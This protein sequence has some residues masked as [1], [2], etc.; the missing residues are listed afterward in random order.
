M[1]ARRAYHEPRTIEEARAELERCAGSQFDPQVVKTFLSVLEEGEQK[2]LEATFS[3][4][5]VPSD[6]K[7]I[8]GEDALLDGMSALAND[9]TPYAKSRKR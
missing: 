5:L 7:T 6:L 1:T 3:G 4:T 8:E 9:L 2:K